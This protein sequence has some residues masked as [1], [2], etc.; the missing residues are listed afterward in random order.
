MTR[1]YGNVQ[2]LIWRD[3]EFRRLNTAD[4]WA[5]LML[6][7]QPDIS[8]CG[9]L[10]VAASRWAR[11]SQDMTEKAVAASLRRLEAHSQRYVVIDVDTDELLVRSF[12]RHD[13]GYTNIKR[14]PAITAAAEAIESPILRGSLN[15]EMANLGV[16]IHLGNSLSPDELDAVFRSRPSLSGMPE[17]LVT[18]Q[19]PVTDTVLTSSGSESSS[20]NESNARAL[21]AVNGGF[22]STEA[23]D[24]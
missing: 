18:V 2:S 21:R 10:T 8:S 15:L 23:G 9:V 12:V 22:A 14:L 24:E 17:V 5:Y 16:D 20:S 4:Q 3:P 19:D 1:E 11:Y 13:K 7:T 6:T